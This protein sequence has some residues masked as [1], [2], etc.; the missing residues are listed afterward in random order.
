MCV[1]ARESGRVCVESLSTWHVSFTCDEGVTGHCAHEP[2]VVDHNIRESWNTNIELCVCV[3]AWVWAYVCKVVPSPARYA[4]HI[5]VTKESC[6]TMRTSHQLSTFI[7]AW[8][9]E[10]K[11]SK[12]T[13]KEYDSLSTF[14]WVVE[15]Y[16]QRVLQCVAVCCSVMQCVAVCCS[17]LQFL[18]VYIH[19]SWN[20]TNYDQ[21]STF[22]FRSRGSVLQC[23]VCVAV[24]C[25]V[26]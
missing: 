8:V 7:Y 3:R 15:H 2:W 23:V 19:E 12:S 18:T 9:M 25:S 16:Q 22:I 1:C 10:Q 13:T 5:Y 26:L 20:T 14:T 24:C 21:M 4:L 6:D 11:K 17:V